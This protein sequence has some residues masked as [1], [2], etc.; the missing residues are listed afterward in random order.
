MSTL[1]WI[2]HLVYLFYTVVVTILI[3]TFTTSA[4]MTTTEQDPFYLRY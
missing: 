3:H 4:I 2:I 1:L